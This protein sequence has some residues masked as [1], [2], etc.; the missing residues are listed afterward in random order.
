MV[1]NSSSYP[2]PAT[3][4]AAWVRRRFA[5][6]REGRFE[7]TKLGVQDDK[8]T[9]RSTSN[10]S[11]TREPVEVLLLPRVFKPLLS[12]SPKSLFLPSVMLL[13]VQPRL[14]VMS[15]CLLCLQ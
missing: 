9:Y 14:P 11:A 3:T 5:K 2:L 8:R 1:T 6:G 13:T 7:F 15:W 12:V 4:F 10:C